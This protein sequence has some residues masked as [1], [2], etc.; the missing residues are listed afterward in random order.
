[1]P[2][3]EQDQLARGW[4]D[5]QRGAW[6][7][8][9]AYD[10]AR[11]HRRLAL[12]V[13]RPGL[14]SVTVVA[15]RYRADVQAAGHADGC[16]GFVV[17]TGSAGAQDMSIVVRD[18][19]QRLGAQAP[20][21]AR[22]LQRRRHGV[23]LHLDW[24]TSGDPALTGYALALR[25]PL[26]RLQLGLRLDGELLSSARATLHRSDVPRW[27]GDSLH[28]FRLGLRPARPSARTLWVE[29]LQTG[30]RLAR[31]DERWRRACGLA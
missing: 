12:E 5:G 1:M 18:T 6:L 14:A 21:R 28:G 27:R 15:D 3:G 31:L 17:R 23:L 2:T 20:R 7:V 24:P 30:R 11:P 13:R 22:R 26:R 4:I 19:G 25:T 9:W 16:C 8:G 29:D 10:P